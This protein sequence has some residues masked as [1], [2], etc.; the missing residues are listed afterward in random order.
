MCDIASFGIL[1]SDKVSCILIAGGSIAFGVRSK[2]NEILTGDLKIKQ[3]PNLQQSYSTSIVSHNGTLLM[4]GGYKENEN[5]CFQ[6]DNG[7]WKEHSVLNESRT[8]HS[9]VTTKTA[10]FLFGGYGNCCTTYEYLL[11]DS[12][13]WLT[14]KTKIPMGFINGTAIAV[15]S[16][17]EIWLIGGKKTD[18]RILA[19]DVS[20]HTFQELPSRLNVMR[21]GHRCAFIPNT[22]KVMITGGM[23][24]REK[25]QNST[26]ILDT[27]D[28]SVYM[29]SPMNCK[30]VEHGMGT[31]TINGEDRLVVFGGTGGNK[32]RITSVEIYNNQTKKWETSKIKL[33]EPRANFS[34]LNVKLSELIPNSK[35]LQGSHDIFEQTFL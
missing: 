3:L 35:Y 32:Q 20:N 22:D 15:K 26:E 14:G 16:G 25:W 29:A 31:M 21:L 34:S 2:F 1:F 17:Q 12:T 33:K 8:Y 19:F 6:L 23:L 30:R 13:T 24:P 28:G 4:C 11:K 10:T 7:L 5:K 9:T 27:N 18:K